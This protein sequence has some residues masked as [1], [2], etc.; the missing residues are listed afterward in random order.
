MTS[1]VLAEG[2]KTVQ[3]SEEAFGFLTQN[4]QPLY[5]ALH[6]AEDPRGVVVMVPPFAEEKKAA[7]RALVEAARAFAESGFNVW[8]FD[9]RGTGDSGG[10][11]D[12]CDVEA[13]LADLRAVLQHARG[14][15]GD[16]PLHVVGLRFGAAL[17]WLAADETLRIDSLALWEPIPSGATY[18]RQNRQRSQIRRQLTDEG[19]QGAATP[20]SAPASTSGDDQA[21]DF[22]GFAIS[23]EL[24]RQI[25]EVDLLAAP[26]PG[27]QRL[28]I[29]QI[30]GSSRIKKPFEELK[31]RAEEAGVQ[32]ELENVAVEAFWSAIGLVDTAPVREK[33]LQ[34]IAREKAEGAPRILEAPAALESSAK[35]SESPAVIAEA[36]DFP[37]GDKRVRGVLYRPEAPVE[38]AVVLLHGWSGY[39]I[40]PGHLLTEAARD[41]AGAGYAALSF[42]FRGRGESE[43]EVGQASL[44]SMIRD[45]ARATPLLLEKTGAEK[46]TLLGLCSGAEV[47]LGASLS[48][49][50]VDTLALW[51]API[52]SGEFTTSRQLR[53]SRESARKYL[54]KLFLPETWAKLVT[55]RLNF[56][57]IARALSGGR[58]NEDAGVKNKAPDTQEQMKEFEAFKGRLLFVYASNDP[59]TVPS[60]D[61]YRAFVE[62]TS[63]AHRFHEV[64]GANHNYYSMVWKREI[65][66]ATL[67]WLRP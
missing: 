37:S 50:R 10:E 12:G 27:V 52:F 4:V 41:L 53:R 29:L 35:V 22:D 31:A 24:Y 54:R 66:E 6:H 42:D 65:I 49:P 64:A 25:R 45:A 14:M 43:W 21:F 18:M 44:N 57:M 30:S 9:F 17:A 3:Q 67:K 23:S 63:M 61:F 8:R 7:Q 38:R 58:S 62:R 28:Q 47:A 40:G 56:K 5:C 13:W 15:A 2:V 46:A 16:S 59:E 19:A 55:G 34:W 11:F 51:S 60:R 33:T 1:Q 39:R 20:T 48:D 32:T 36:F 26:V